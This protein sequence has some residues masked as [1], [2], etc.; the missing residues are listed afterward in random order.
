MDSK[1]IVE[2]GKNTLGSVC[3]GDKDGK[4]RE[5]VNKNGELSTICIVG[6]SKCSRIKVEDI[7]MVEKDGRKVN[8]YTADDVYEVYD[9]INVIA[10]KLV[11]RGFYRALK[12][13]IINFDKVKEIDTSFITFESGRGYVIGRNNLIKTKK[14]FRR[15]LMSYPPFMN[16]EPQSSLAE[17]NNIENKEI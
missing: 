15:Y 1:R 6:A 3:N 10:E 12:S 16:W 13:V 8:I 11:E 14:A 4:L 17:A 2:L 7:E 9:K 5:G